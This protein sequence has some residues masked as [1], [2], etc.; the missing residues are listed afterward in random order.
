MCVTSRVR[1]SCSVS[2]FEIVKRSPHE[3]HEQLKAMVDDANALGKSGV[4]AAKGTGA[5]KVLR[6]YG[7]NM[8]IAT[9]F[10][11]EVREKPEPVVVSATYPGARMAALQPR[12]HALLDEKRAEVGFVHRNCTIG[13][14]Y[15]CLYTYRYPSSRAHFFSGA[16]SLST[17]YWRAVGRPARVCHLP[18]TPRCTAKKTR[19]RWAAKHGT[20]RTRLSR[21][22]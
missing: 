21:R 20:P 18:R 5:Q 11:V 22:E 16:S 8:F 3:P 4:G 13:R 10:K 7:A 6:K 2:R 1:L 9:E 17:Q 15:P 19:L 12:F 14:C